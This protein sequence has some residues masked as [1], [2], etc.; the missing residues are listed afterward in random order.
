MRFQTII[1]YSHM[2]TFLRNNKVN[3]VLYR[4][5]WGRGLYLKMGLRGML[6]CNF[7]ELEMYLAGEIMIVYLLFVSE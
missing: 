7:V 4:I 2:K 3:H 6:V 5:N 1:G